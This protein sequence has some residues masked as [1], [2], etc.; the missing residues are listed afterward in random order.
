MDYPNAYSK[1]GY[2]YSTGKGVE[3]D[4]TKA[5]KFFEDGASKGDAE[6]IYNLGNLYYGGCGVEKD[7]KKAVQ[8][9]E[10]AAQKNYSISYVVLGK[11][12]LEGEGVDKD[13][14]KGLN[15]IRTA[16]NLGNEDAIKIVEIYDFITMNSQEE[17][18]GNGRNAFKENTAQL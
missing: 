11:M 17:A 7:I 16:A 5:F 18:A 1:I 10:L 2:I 4:H 3:I 6:A 8:C 14:E 12:Y 15:C 9:F 13:R